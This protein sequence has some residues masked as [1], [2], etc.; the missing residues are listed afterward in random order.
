MGPPLAGCGYDVDVA[1]QEE[2]GAAVC[3]GQASDEIRPVGIAGVELAPHARGG[4]E[5]ANVLDALALRPRRV[6]GIEAK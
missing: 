4:E 3:S 1:V 6:R 5:L 2:G